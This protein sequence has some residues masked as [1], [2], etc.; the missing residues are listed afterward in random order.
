MTAGRFCAQCGREAG[1]GAFCQHCGASQ[2][3]A[4][5]PVQA[6]PVSAFCPN[7]GTKAEPGLAFCTNC[8]ANLA[9]G[10]PLTPSQYVQHAAA[11]PSKTPMYVGA[12]AAVVALIVA[13]ILLSGGGDDK[14]SSTPSQATTGG[15]ASSSSSSAGN[16]ATGPD[17]AKTDTN[18]VASYPKAVARNA[19]APKGSDRYLDSGNNNVKAAEEMKAVIQKAGVNV[20]GAEFFVFPIRGTVNTMLVIDAPSSAPMFSSSSSASAMNS[21][22]EMKKFAAAIVASPTIKT[23]RITSLTMNV[24]DKDQQGPLVVTFGLPITALEGLAKGTLS[25]A[26]LQKQMVLGTQRR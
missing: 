5:P 2:A 15:G 16:S 11:V 24:R 1:G 3:V 4:P 13:V 17:T 6:A 8:G 25:D 26:E 21:D 19:P 23:A 14:S 9:T 22:A 12:G 10:V 20:T 18:A 7:C